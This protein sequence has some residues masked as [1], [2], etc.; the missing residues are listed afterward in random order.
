MLEEEDRKRRRFNGI[1]SA[2]DRNLV[3]KAYRYNPDIVWLR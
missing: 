1:D 2:D 3:P